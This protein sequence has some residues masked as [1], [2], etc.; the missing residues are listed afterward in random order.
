MEEMVLNYYQELTLE[1]LGEMTATPNEPKQSRRVT[2]RKKNQ[3]TRNLPLK[4]ST[5]ICRWQTN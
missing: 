2:K 3:R 1:E 4:Q 5:M